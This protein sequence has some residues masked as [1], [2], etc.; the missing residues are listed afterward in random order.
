MKDKDEVI[1]ISESYQQMMHQT[2]TTSRQK[3]MRNSKQ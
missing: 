1:M 3:Y 2:M